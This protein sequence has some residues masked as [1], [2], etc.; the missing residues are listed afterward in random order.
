MTMPTSPLLVAL[1]NAQGVSVVASALA[2]GELFLTLNGRSF[3]D[4]S[5][6]KPISGIV[7]LYW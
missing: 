2:Q 7:R 3:N 1:G 4:D 5:N 6:R